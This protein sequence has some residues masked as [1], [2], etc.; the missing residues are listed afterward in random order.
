MW[1]IQFPP[2][3]FNIQLPAAA[4][5]VD[6]LV[7]LNAFFSESDY[8]FHNCCSTEPISQKW[9]LISKILCNDLEKNVQDVNLHLYHFHLTRGSQK[10]PDYSAI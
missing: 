8:P 4:S 10:T 6:S 2:T 5:K 9:N 7:K 1:E 3:S